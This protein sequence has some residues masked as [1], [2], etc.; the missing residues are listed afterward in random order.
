[1]TT[2]SALQDRRGPLPRIGP[3]QLTSRVMLSPMAGITDAPFRALA[4]QFGAA[5]A[6]SEMTTADT[7]LWHTAKS[8]HRLDIDSDAEPRVVQIAGSE[9]DAMAQAAQAVVARGAHIVDIN[10]GCPAKKVCKKLAGSALLQDIVLVE[11]ILTA[12]VGAVD[13]P[14]TLKTRLGWDEDHQ[15]IIE[16]ASIA[17]SAGIAALAIHGRT[18]ACRYKGHARYELI[19]AVKH[20]L[21]IPVFANGDIDSAQKA[22]AVLDQTHAD[23]VLIGRA[24]QG[25]PWILRDISCFIATGEFPTPLLIDETHAIIRCHLDA[26][27][28]FYGERRGVLM[29][30]KHLNW[31]CKRLGIADDIRRVLLSLPSSTSQ[32]ELAEKV[33]AGSGAAS[34]RAPERVQQPNMLSWGMANRVR[35]QQITKT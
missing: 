4:R 30:R 13:V 33:F 20:A 1:M 5:M 34:A 25:M 18:R 28:R 29:G 31:Y 15:N 32:R 35:E 27:H 19:S 2:V 22:Q 24:T 21:D 3:Y 10:M 23:G 16:V 8:S 7:R 9:P 14:V 26:V 11:D 12:V 17:Q 6:A